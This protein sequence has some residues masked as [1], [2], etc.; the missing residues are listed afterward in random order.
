MNSASNLD[1]VRIRKS[2]RVGNGV[3]HN[4][5]IKGFL[6][7]FHFPFPAVSWST[8]FWYF[9]SF[10][11]LLNFEPSFCT[12]R[13]NN[14]FIFS[15]LKS[16]H[17]PLTYTFFPTSSTI[18]AKH[19]FT[20]AVQLRSLCSPSDCH[21]LFSSISKKGD[22]SFLKSSLNYETFVLKTFLH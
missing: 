5:F 20:N 14:L 8:I 3:L 7:P 4:G 12:F 11:C 22:I 9:G 19:S 6:C 18:L 21:P 1:S 16:I 13:L 17:C 2:S 10:S 15:L